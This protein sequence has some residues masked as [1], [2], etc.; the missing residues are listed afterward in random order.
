[1][2]KGA[3]RVEASVQNQQLALCLFWALT[4]DR[5]ARKF[6]IWWIFSDLSHGWLVCF[7]RVQLLL[8]QLCK[9]QVPLKVPA[10]VII[11]IIIVIIIIMKMIIVIIIIMKIIIVS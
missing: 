4:L 11:K 8:D 3:G 1:M 5:L 6:I 9:L 7:V 10:I 2:E